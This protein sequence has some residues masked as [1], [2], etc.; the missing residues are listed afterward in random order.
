MIFLFTTLWFFFLTTPRAQCIFPHEIH[1]FFIYFQAW[2][3]FKL[4]CSSSCFSAVLIFQQL[5]FLSS[6]KCFIFNDYKFITLTFIV[7]HSHHSQAWYTNLRIYL[8]SLL[9]TCSHVNSQPKYLLTLFLMF[10]GAP[11]FKH[12]GKCCLLKPSPDTRPHAAPA[13]AAHLQV[14]PR[15]TNIYSKE[16]RLRPLIRTMNN[17]LYGRW[18]V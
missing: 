18:K 12:K 15:G 9:L 6:M 14:I 10:L 11:V 16:A 5:F 8:L 4:K 17:Y 7:N 1:E 13:S 2:Y 3:I